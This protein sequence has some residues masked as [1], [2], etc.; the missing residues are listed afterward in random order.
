MLPE[1]SSADS[2]G[3]G[4]S[5]RWPPSSGSQEACGSWTGSRCAPV[6]SKTLYFH[7]VHFYCSITDPQQKSENPDPTL[8]MAAGSGFC[9]FFADQIFFL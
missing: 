8:F 7:S 4:S 6:N 9:I 2:C 5:R 3:C 1:V